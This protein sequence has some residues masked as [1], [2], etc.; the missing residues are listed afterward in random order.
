MQKLETYIKTSEDQIFDTSKEIEKISNKLYRSQGLQEK[1]LAN[2]DYELKSVLIVFKKKKNLREK[3][4]R[5]VKDVNSVMEEKEGMLNELKKKLKEVR[6]EIALN[7]IKMNRLNNEK[8][9]N[10]EQ[11]R[12]IQLSVTIILE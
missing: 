11:I 10:A 2:L 4:E 6:D 3:V 8:A 12:K 5:E 7:K 9:S 1:E